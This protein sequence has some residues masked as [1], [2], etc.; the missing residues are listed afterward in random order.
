MFILIKNDTT[1]KTNLNAFLMCLDTGTAPAVGYSRTVTAVNVNDSALNGD[2]TLLQNQAAAGNID[3]IAKG[4]LDGRRHGLFINRVRE[5]TR[6]TRPGW[7]RSR[8]RS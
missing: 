4:I 1:R 6:P 3:L 5:H 2:W 7:G 8:S